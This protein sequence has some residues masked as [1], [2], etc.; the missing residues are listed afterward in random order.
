MKN[1]TNK[2]EIEKKK[3]KVLPV[4]IK[5]KCF[6]SMFLIKFHVD[7]CKCMKNKEVALK[8]SKE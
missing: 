2:F 4:I 7:L 3:L 1:E 6:K 8:L 5:K